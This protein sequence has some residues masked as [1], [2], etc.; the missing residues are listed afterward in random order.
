M[1]HPATSTRVHARPRRRGVRGMR[2]MTVLEIMIVLAVIGGL[3]FI[4]RTGFRVLTRADLVEDSTE[5]T[6]VMRRASQIAVEHGELHRVVIDLD[7]QAYAVEVCQGATAIQRN[8]RLNSNDDE[9]KRAL[10][11]GK[12][13]LNGLPADALASGD[14][15]DATKRASALA[16][17]H[18][19]DRT[20]VPATDGLTLDASGKG[21]LRKL[22]KDNGIKFKQVFVQHRDDPALKGQVA[23]YFFP[24][25]QS[26][27]S[28]VEL[29]DGS[30]VFSVLVFGLT[31]RVELHD[32]ALRDVNDHM[33]KNA[34]LSLIHISEPTRLLSISYA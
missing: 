22:R 30:E 15:E 6:A 9:A 19:A 11:R 18:V 29:T 16:G 8:E 3:F 2:G 7:N 23:I 34:M 1:N 4:V 31:G 14:P 27:K 13:R 33:L 10:E 17:H 28:V 20:C 12:Q 21:W 5:L 26:E 32:G 24:L 25:G